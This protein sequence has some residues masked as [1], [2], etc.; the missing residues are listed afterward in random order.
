[1]IRELDI[2]SREFK[3]P[4]DVTV[5]RKDISLF[6]TDFKK[7]VKPFLDET[8]KTATKEKHSKV[9]FVSISFE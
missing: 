7:E 9:I 3:N 4:R 1:M 8:E 5:I 2:I 6:Q